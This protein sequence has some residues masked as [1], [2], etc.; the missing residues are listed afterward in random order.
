V[1]AVTKLDVLHNELKSSEFQYLWS[2]VISLLEHLTRHKSWRRQ[3]G[4]IV[5][6]AHNTVFG[7]KRSAICVT[8]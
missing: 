6:N 2:G 3:D 8:V 7:S 4:C 1:H 5:C